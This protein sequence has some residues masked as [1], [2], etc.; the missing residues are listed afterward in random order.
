MLRLSHFQRLL[1]LAVV[2]ALLIYGGS[3]AA[4]AAPNG[5]IVSDLGFR[6]ETNGFPFENYG[7][8]FTNLT[9]D[10]MH[11]MFGDTVCASNA[12][13]KCILTP[14]AE[15]W[16]IQTNE[17]MAGGHCFGFSV[18]SLRMFHDKGLAASMGA[19][20]IIGLKLDGNDKLQR[21]LAY[22][23]AFQKFDTVREGT[24]VG[25]PNAVL[26]AL[27]QFLDPKTNTP[28]L[29][30]IGF[31]KAEGG[32]GH[33]V[34]PYAVEDRGNGMFAVMIYDNNFP[35]TV[36]EIMFDTNANK[37]SYQASTNP[38]EPSSLYWGDADTKSLFLFPT[39]P[40]L[41]PQACTFCQAAASSSRP[42]GL[43]RMVAG[44]QQYN[45]IYLDGATDVHA[46]LLITDSQ[47][48]RTGYV[49]NKLV[50][51]IPDVVVEESFSGDLFK[52][53]PEPVYK[54]PTGMQFTLT[55]DG[56]PLQQQD[57]TDVILIGPGY[58]L[59]VFDIKLDPGQMDTLTLSPDGTKLSYK[60]SGGESPDI[61]LGL[62]HSGAD[63]EF[64]VKGVEI[65]NG[66]TVNAALDFAQ[67]RLSVST[68]GETNPATFGIVLSRIDDQGEQTFSHDD[69]VTLAIG[70]TAFLDY[71]KWSGNG[72]EL[73][74]D[75]D[76]GSD[77]T[78]DES[79]P[80]TDA[81]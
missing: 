69:G 68:S 14:P 35:K 9:P 38:N 57:L 76:K 64:L 51:E 56:S 3:H 50:K 62:E 72:G 42:A 13:G 70:D 63:Y 44:P 52:D 18:L 47:G 40:G 36:R 71:G 23:W 74:I 60:P 78:V 45:E 53:S 1:V 67:G 46:H 10:E 11:R 30:T 5:A 4:T 32:G 55:I 58:D 73:T 49:G 41:Q 31:F 81:E 79:V 61:V 77:G 12:E 6:P 16:M 27:I 59:G 28:E 22:S 25:T 19:D 26:K 65:D 20:D 17:A 15:Q 21:E 34:T 80:L 48:R 24:L 66:G 54:V 33:A 8:G 29:Y 75:I 37:W 43:A 39:T 2:L 7:P